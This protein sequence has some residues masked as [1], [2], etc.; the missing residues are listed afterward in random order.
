MSCGKGSL[1]KPALDKPL[2]DSEG[3]LKVAMTSRRGKAFGKSI[4]KTGEKSL[5]EC[6][7][8]T[9]GGIQLDFSNILS[10][11]STITGI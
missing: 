3:V 4:D 2:S 11:S 6:F 7:A 5:P 10:D 9:D 8:P 1:G